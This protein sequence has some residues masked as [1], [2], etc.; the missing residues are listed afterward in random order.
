ML[1]P[2]IKAVIRARPYV[3]QRLKYEIFNYGN[4]T[5]YPAEFELYPVIDRL[6]DQF[7]EA[8]RVGL[9]EAWLAA[10]PR[11]RNLSDDEI[12]LSYRAMIVE[13]IVQRAETAAYRSNELEG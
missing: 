1:G 2:V 8:T 4:Q 9:V 5:G 12:L 13:V 3:W 6:M 10:K 7:D 11:R